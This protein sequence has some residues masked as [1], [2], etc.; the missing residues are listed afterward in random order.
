MKKGKINLLS[1]ENDEGEETIEIQRKKAPVTT[2]LNLNV[3]KPVFDFSRIKDRVIQMELEEGASVILGGEAAEAF[4]EDDEDYSDSRDILHLKMVSEAKLKRA[5]KLD[6]EAFLAAED[7][8]PIAT[9]GDYWLSHDTRESEENFTSSS[10]RLVREDLFN[11]IEEH[12]PAQAYTSFTGKSTEGR[13]GLMMT[14]K[15]LERDIKTSG[16]YDFELD[17]DDDDENDAE[18]DALW[19]KGQVLK[20]IE[21]GW[22]GME[23]ES[24]F[25]SKQ[26]KLEVFIP[27]PKPFPSP[28]SPSDL[29][30]LETTNVLEGNIEKISEDSNSLKSKIEEI[31]TELAVA[32]TNLKN[33]NELETFFFRFSRFLSEKLAELAEI[34]K[35]HD[36]IR[37]E[38]FFDDTDGDEG[39]LLNLPD[40]LRKSQVLFTASNLDYY[41]ELTELF[42]K[43][44]FLLL[45]FEPDHSIA[46]IWE[47]SG[48]KDALSAIPNVEGLLKDIFDQEPEK[49]EKISKTI[50]LNL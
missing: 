39:D 4:L 37:W 45:D 29:F 33:F 1:F 43:Y 9:K 31:K 5:N 7:Y 40:I 35:N 38:H 49:Y 23:S 20:G 48:L 41:K 6:N 44:H 12:D 28:F 2:N 32:T 17:N 15:I 42:V 24:N 13:T 18:G 21:R 8:I 3:T 36:R 47:R 26:T 30:S 34:E 11:E 27:P 19:Q 46:A 16:D 14:R 22:N 25:Y 50:N 10:T